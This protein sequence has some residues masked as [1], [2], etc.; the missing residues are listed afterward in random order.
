MADSEQGSAPS[1]VVIDVAGLQ[2]PLET[3]YKLAVQFY[4]DA[5]RRAEFEYDATA[6]LMA[7]HK[8]V[9][10]G[11]L[12]ED[13]EP[14]LGWFDFV[15]HD[16]RAAWEELGDMSKEEAMA[17]FV[18]TCE[19]NHETFSK[20]L[21]TKLIE[22]EEERKERERKEQERLEQ[23]RVERERLER[24]ELARKEQARLESLRQEQEAAARAE[25]ARLQQLS[26][27]QSQQMQ[28]PTN[29]GPSTPVA[30]PQSQQAQTP[31]ATNP[32]S[33]I[34][35]DDFRNSLR[36]KPDFTLSV[37]RGE[38]VRVRVPNPKPGSTCVSWIFCSELYDVGF[39]LDYELSA[40]E[41]SVVTI[42]PV[43]R[44]ESHEQLCFGSHT[45]AE[46]GNW[47]L[48][49]DNSY[50]ILRSKTVYYRCDLQHGS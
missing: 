12:N 8:Q 17:E 47:L 30:I 27:Q 4:R 25:Q 24:E 48:V 26:A 43:E 21:E 28:P 45:K 50:S 44:K 42:I 16:R 6:L 41:D 46:K 31:G 33:G 34:K 14:A 37:G 15:G 11:P 10:S 29:A 22:I 35:L 5:T 19:Q 1:S 38:V 36:E 13:T 20:W 9:T 2:A 7:L 39:G 49:F 23:E 40:E 32:Y 18:K 3:R